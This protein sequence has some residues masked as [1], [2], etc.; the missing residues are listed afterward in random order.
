MLRKLVKY[1]HVD[2]DFLEIPLSFFYRTT[3][4][5]QSFCVP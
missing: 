4:E 1:H 3:D 2:P 5:E